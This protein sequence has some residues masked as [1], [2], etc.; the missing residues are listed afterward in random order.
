MTT[1]ST[2]RHADF[3]PNSELPTCPWQ[4]PVQGPLEWHRRTWKSAHEPTG[5]GLYL[6]YRRFARSEIPS[7]KLMTTT[8]PINPRSAW[9]NRT[10][11]TRALSRSFQYHRASLSLD[12]RYEADLISV[13]PDPALHSAHTGDATLYRHFIVRPMKPVQTS[14]QRVV[15][16]K[17]PA[18]CP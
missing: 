9:C 1:Y 13:G 15:S 5:Y 2:A 16:W 4:L 3:R 12:E 17:S 18:H 14:P 11:F 6:E 10:Y 7:M 8:I